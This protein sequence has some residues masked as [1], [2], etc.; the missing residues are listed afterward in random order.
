MLAATTASFGAA[1]SDTFDTSRTLPP[2]G[3]LGA[4]L[5]GVVCDRVGA[6]SLHEDLTG[7][8][9]AG[10]CHAAADGSYT[11][12][13]DTTKLPPLVDDQPDVDGVPVPLAK[14][15]SDRTY[16]VARI[17]TLAKHRTDLI[18]ALDFTMPS[19]NVAIKDVGNA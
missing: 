11:S 18:T 1:C 7:A 14:Q 4:E 13:V 2:R 12:T 10:I 16:A 6:Q 8:S 5:F 9:Y 15:Q 19:E 3:T 17:E